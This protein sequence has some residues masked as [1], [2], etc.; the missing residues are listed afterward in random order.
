MRSLISPEDID[1]PFNYVFICYPHHHGTFDEYREERRLYLMSYCLSL[2]LKYPHLKQVTGMTFEN[3]AANTFSVEVL[4]V[5][6]DQMSNEDLA[7]TS[8]VREEFEMLTDLKAWEPS[9]SDVQGLLS[10]DYS[11]FAPK[12]LKPE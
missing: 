3:S 12:N 1:N 4:S 10:G 8:Q 9:V 5:D 2:K 7:H 6:L 11:G